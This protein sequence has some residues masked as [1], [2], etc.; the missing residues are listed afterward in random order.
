MLCSTELITTQKATLE[1]VEKHGIIAIVPC[2][3]RE[4]IM[5]L[6]SCE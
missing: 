6:V 2:C 3:T 1:C 4:Y 5:G